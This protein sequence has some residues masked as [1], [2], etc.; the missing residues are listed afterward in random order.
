MIDEKL[1]G[2]FYLDIPTGTVNAIPP[3]VVLRRGSVPRAYLTQRVSIAAPRYHPIL[4]YL[5]AYHP[6][7][8]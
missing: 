1:A 5:Y 7:T 8:R 3:P 2:L 4:P 6:A